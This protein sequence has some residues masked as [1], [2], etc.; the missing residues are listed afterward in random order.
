MKT[1]TILFALVALAMAVVSLPAKAE[2]KAQAEEA[3]SPRKICKWYGGV[4]VG[5]STVSQVPVDQQ[6]QLDANKYVEVNYEVQRHS[7]PY[8]FTVGCEGSYGLGFE[9]FTMDRITAQ[10]FNHVSA[11]VTIPHTDIIAGPSADVI[12]KG[13]VRLQGLKFLWM[14]PPKQKVRGFIGMDAAYGVGQLT[15]TVKFDRKEFTLLY[16]RKGWVPA[17]EAGLQIDQGRCFARFTWV[18]FPAH[19]SVAHATLGWRF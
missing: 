8:G 2:E 7:I 9:G 6:Q 13:D 10:I 15:A 12:E 16:E 4:T 5:I 11:G 17:L 14:F 1:R 18:Q 19:V 3:Q